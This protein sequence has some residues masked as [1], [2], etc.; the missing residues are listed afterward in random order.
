VFPFAGLLHQGGFVLKQCL[1]TAALVAVALPGAAHADPVSISV[2]SLQGGATAS[3]PDTL[4]FG[5]PIPIGEITLPTAGAAAAISVG[6]LGARGNYLMEVMVHGASS[7]WNTLRAEVLDPLDPLDHDDHLD[8]APYHAGVPD[9][10]STSNTRDGLSFAQ[11]AGLERSAVFAGG[12]ALVSADEDTNGADLLMFSGVAGATGALRVTFGLR[13]YDGNRNFLVRFSA[14]D[15]VATPEPAS[16]FLIGTG[17][18][19]LAALRSRRRREH[20]DT[21]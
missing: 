10:F 15:A 17:L 11:S 9:G 7:S 20:G 3:L 8:V 2:H 21:H 19:G 16:M 18:A 14:E 4:T 12:S 5:S 13:D 6:G 1:V